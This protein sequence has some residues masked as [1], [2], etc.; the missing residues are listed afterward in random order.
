MKEKKISLNE[1]PFTSTIKIIT[2][3]FIKELDKSNDYEETVIMVYDFAD[4]MKLLVSVM[5]DNKEKAEA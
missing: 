4:S 1:D 3:D 5:L 2:K